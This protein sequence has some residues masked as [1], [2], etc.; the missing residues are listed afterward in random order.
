MTSFSSALRGQ[1]AGTIYF[2]LRLHVGQA[3]LG[4]VSVA[5]TGFLIE[6]S[7]DTVQSA[8]VAYLRMD[9]VPSGG[10]PHGFWPF[11]PDLAVEVIEPRD[12]WGTVEEKAQTWLK[13]GALLVW[14]VDPDSRV[15]H[16]H[17]PDGSIT[18]LTRD[19][20]LTGE[21]VVPGFSVQ[22]ADL[23]VMSKG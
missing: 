11:G 13:A 14:I 4:L 17:R 10:P 7:P 12:P 20:T 6:R 15:I 19:D 16:I 5:R 23:F 3:G 9:R 21:N 2:L 22:V 18:K 1:V 8:D